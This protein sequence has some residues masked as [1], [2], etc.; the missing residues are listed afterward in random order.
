MPELSRERLEGFLAGVIL[1]LLSMLALAVVGNMVKTAW[2]ALME[3]LAELGYPMPVTEWVLGILIF[4]ALAYIGV[5][6]VQKY[7]VR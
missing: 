3:H 5:I 4:L 1:M 2:R 7:L 6:K